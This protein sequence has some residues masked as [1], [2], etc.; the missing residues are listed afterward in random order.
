MTRYRCRSLRPKVSS[1]SDLEADSPEDAAQEHLG[2]WFRMDALRYT[3]DLENPGSHIY[4]SLVEV[5][6]HGEMVARLYTSGI[7]RAGGVKPR[8]VQTREQALA[9]IAKQ[10]GW[11]K[12]PA[13]LLDAGWDGEEPDWR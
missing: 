8:Q 12:D 2:R 9:D 10:I 4:F 11:E 5:E 7:V 3:P 1:W 6:G 13:L